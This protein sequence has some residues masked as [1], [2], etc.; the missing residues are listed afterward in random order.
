MTFIAVQ[1]PVIELDDADLEN[2][3]DTLADSLN[4]DERHRP[5]EF[6]NLLD[7]L[8]EQQE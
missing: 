5:S 2:Q 4:N 3:L 1:T 7:N 6:R 8:R